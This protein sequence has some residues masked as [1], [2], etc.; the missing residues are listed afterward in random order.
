M[1]K[2]LV[3]G[4]FL[5][6]SAGAIIIML[7]K[8]SIIH[9]QEERLKQYSENYSLLLERFKDLDSRHKEL[10]KKYIVLEAGSKGFR[11]AEEHLKAIDKLL[12]QP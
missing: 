9:H 8:D 1:R 5:I 10:D 2:A 7:S 4:F 3:C 11:E 12:R 6:W